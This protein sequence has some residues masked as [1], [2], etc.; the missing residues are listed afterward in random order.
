MISPP[1]APIRI[2]GMGIDSPRPRNS[3]L[4]NVSLTLTS[5]LHAV[6]TRTIATL[7]MAENAHRMMGPRTMSGGSCSTAKNR[8]RRVHRPH[9]GT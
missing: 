2:T 9:A 4:R 1:I 6:N 5:R 7:S 8:I 3:G